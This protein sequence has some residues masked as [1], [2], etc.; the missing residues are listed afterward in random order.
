MRQADINVVILSVR[1]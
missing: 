1:L